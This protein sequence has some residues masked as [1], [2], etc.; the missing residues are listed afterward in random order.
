M[1]QN[2]QTCVPNLDYRPAGGDMLDIE[3][4]SVASLRQRVGPQRMRLPRQ[5]A[6]GMLLFM[7]KG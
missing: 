1:I 3:I 7:S 4:F 6:F 5:Y 2:G